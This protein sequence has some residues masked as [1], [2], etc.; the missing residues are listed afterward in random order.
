MTS[1]AIVFWA[2]GIF[3]VIGAFMTI[4]RRH[5]VASVMWLVLTFLGMAAIFVGM[6]AYFVAVIQVLVYAGAIMV[7]FLFVIMLL[8]LKADAVF[9]VGG[10]VLQ[11][12]A[13]AA[14]VALFIG[15]GLVV[16]ASTNYG[17]PPIVPPLAADQSQVQLIARLIFTKYLL[18]FE[19]TSVLLLAAIVGAVVIS[20]RGRTS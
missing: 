14:G 17:A 11:V 10:P 18:P 12:T 4:T 15:L 5:P 13:V 8:D 20:R 3:S 1:E 16:R 19:V 2:A 9:K 7:L 6:E